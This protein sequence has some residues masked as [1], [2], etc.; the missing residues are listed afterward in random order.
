MALL[1]NYCLV[2]VQSFEAQQIPLELST[3]TV[4]KKKTV[5]TERERERERERCMCH[6]TY[7]IESM[8]INFPVANLGAL[9]GVVE[10]STE[11][12]DNSSN[13]G[14]SMEDYIKH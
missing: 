9:D 4:N 12:L 1:G 8:A 6:F 2:S 14:I 10:F 7:R 3:I 11:P 5:S 13:L